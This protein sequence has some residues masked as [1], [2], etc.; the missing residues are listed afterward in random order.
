MIEKREDFTICRLKSLFP[1][2]DLTGITKKM[3]YEF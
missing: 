2:K 3:D 1:G